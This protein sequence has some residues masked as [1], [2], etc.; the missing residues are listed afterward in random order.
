MNH[1]L[2]FKFNFETGSYT[3]AAELMHAALEK[4]K[5]FEPNSGYRS[6]ELNLLN[7]QHDQKAASLTIHTHDSVIREEAKDEDWGN[8]IEKVFSQVEV[9]S[10][11][12]IKID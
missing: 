5:A 3:A 7:S 1:Q 8:A 11:H 4:I 12:T 2:S 9:T 10:H 6:I